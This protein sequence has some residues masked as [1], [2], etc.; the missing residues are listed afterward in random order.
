MGVWKTKILSSKRG[1]TGEFETELAKF[2]NVGWKIKGYSY[3]DRFHFALLIKE[4]E[5]TA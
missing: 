3:H 4:H 1:K 5:Q 2:L